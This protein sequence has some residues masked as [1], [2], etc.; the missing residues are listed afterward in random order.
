MSGLKGTLDDA[1]NLT[2]KLLPILVDAYHN[3]DAG[4]ATRETLDGIVVLAHDLASRLDNLILQL[5][6]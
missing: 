4:P 5:R 6:S 2:D 1:S 3:E